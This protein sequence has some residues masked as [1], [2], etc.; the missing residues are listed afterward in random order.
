MRPFILASLIACFAGSA[1]S[2]SAGY[3]DAGSPGEALGMMHSTLVVTEKMLTECSARFPQ[4]APEM[5]SNLRQWEDRER[6]VIV[7]TRY[8]W[9]KVAKRDAKLQELT[10][11]Y[12]AAVENNLKTVARMPGA[13]ESGA[14]ADYCRK[15]F[16]NLASGV[17]RLRTPRA[18]K[19]LDE[20]PAVPQ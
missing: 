20:A 11:Y 19:Y 16:A 3:S 15:H 2:Q 10:P 1:F 8:H 5:K 4:H 13:E 7:K 9:A 12:E 17:W 18:Y 6:Q 14:V